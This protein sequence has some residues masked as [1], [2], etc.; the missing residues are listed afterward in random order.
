MSMRNVT[1]FVT[2][3]IMVAIMKHENLQKW[4]EGQ[5]MRGR[6]IFTKEDVKALDLNITPV[7]LRQSLFRMRKKGI[8]ISPWKGFYVAVPTEYR[9]KG[10]VPPSFY[11]DHLMKYL[12]RKYYVSLLSAAAINGAGHQRAMVFQVTVEGVQLRSGVKNGTQLNFNYKKTIPDF[13]LNKIKVQTGYMNVSSAELT[14]LDI[15]D[16]E[17]K[18]GGLSRAAEILV[19]LSEKLRWDSEKLSLLA[20]FS[21]PVC[22]RLGFLFDLIGENELADNL[23]ALLRQSGKILRKVRLKQEKEVNEG[24]EFDSKWKIIINHEIEIDEI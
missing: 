19:E 13:Y 1:I 16:Q 2:I 20:L 24:M 7:G 6:Y 4:L 14:A 18:I 22:Q 11:I 9:L 10:E 17:G 12:G 15:V 23:L 21:A 3:R 5:M 8:L